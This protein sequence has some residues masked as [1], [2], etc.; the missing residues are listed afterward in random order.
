M[1]EPQIRLIPKPMR[2]LHFLRHDDVLNAD[3]EIPVLVVS[4][5]VGEHVPRRE[6][7]LAV[8]DAR[9]DANRALVHVEVR[10]D[11]V[12]RA[13]AVIEAL[14]PQELAGEGVEGE[15]GR[16]LGEDGGVEGDDAF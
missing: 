11:A 14:S 12:A 9:A 13:V 7:D 2:R 4:R 15:A 8:L 16:S 1:L 3:A 5:L 10:P 6:G